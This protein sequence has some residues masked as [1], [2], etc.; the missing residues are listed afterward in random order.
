MIIY[1]HFRVLALKRLTESLSPFPNSPSLQLHLF[2]P[3]LLRTYKLFRILRL[4]NYLKVVPIEITRVTDVLVRLFNPSRF[5][6]LNKMYLNHNYRVITYMQGPSYFVVDKP[7]NVP[8]ETSEASRI[9][10][11]PF[12]NSPLRVTFSEQRHFLSLRAP[13]F[14]LFTKSCLRACLRPPIPC[15]HQSPSSTSIRLK[16]PTVEKRFTLPP[17]DSIPFIGSQAY[18]RILFHPRLV[19]VLWFARSPKRSSR[20]FMVSW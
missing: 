5:T 9:L 2:K 10:V 8:T 4:L 15:F 6:P 20:W 7:F 18:G 19:F 17:R 1:I 16:L 3:R 13:L 14:P 11:I 12:P